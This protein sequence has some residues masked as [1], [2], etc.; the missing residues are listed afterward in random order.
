MASIIIS[1]KFKSRLEKM[2]V[3]HQETNVGKK[4]RD[5]GYIKRI[6]D[7]LYVLFDNAGLN[8][9]GILDATTFWQ[10]VMATEIAGLW[11]FSKKGNLN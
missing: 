7:G 3:L 4:L 11:D 9:I 1:E 6:E 10:A 5:S 2:N 8:G